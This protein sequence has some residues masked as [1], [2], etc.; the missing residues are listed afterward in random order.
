M[1]GAEGPPGT[2]VG[3]FGRVENVPVKVEIEIVVKGSPL[4]IARLDVIE[5]DMALIPGVAWVH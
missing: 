4:V 2:E 3:M 1:I 5:D